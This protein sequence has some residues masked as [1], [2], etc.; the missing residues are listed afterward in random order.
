MK[1]GIR[2]WV[3]LFV[4][5]LFPFEA[6]LMAKVHKGIWYHQQP[7]RANDQ[8]VFFVDSVGYEGFCGLVTSAMG[9]HYFI[10]NIHAKLY[11]IFG[12]V[13]FHPQDD[14]GGLKAKDPYVY[15]PKTTYP[16]ED[17]L[18]HKYVGRHVTTT[19]VA[20]WEIQNI[21]RGVS[22]DIGDYTCRTKWVP[23][24]KIKSY[25]DQNWLVIMN[26]KQ[27]GGHYIL[28]VGWEGDSANIAKQFYYVWDPWKVPLG[29]KENEYELVVDLVGNRANIGTAK[30]ISAYKISGTVF[31]K[32][33][34]DQREDSTVFAFQCLPQN[35]PDINKTVSMKSLWIK[36]LKGIK[37]SDVISVAKLNGV[38][39]LFVNSASETLLQ[40]VVRS[41]HAAGLKVHIVVSVFKDFE[42]S[43]KFKHVEKKW[44]NATDKTYL[45]WFMSHRLKAAMKV[46]PDGIVLNDLWQPV[47]QEGYGQAGKDALTEYCI[48]IKQELMR[49]KSTKKITL[50]AVVPKEPSLH[51]QDILAMSGYLDAIIPLT[52]THTYEEG[53]ARI[54]QWVH[55]L[56]TTIRHG[57]KIWP[58]LETVDRDSNLMTPLEM[59][60]CTAFALANGADAIIYAQYP[61]AEWQWE[62]VDQWSVLKKK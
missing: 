29:L 40:S 57:C 61:L 4:F 44:I 26:S 24:D 36:D 23:F 58:V 52:L 2:Y 32:I 17:F 22:K 56:K 38:T 7:T 8:G 13:D 16:F 42:H 55:R 20:Y 45:N 48:R 46:L 41:A 9:L 30:N 10:P 31:K 39:D 19:G 6:V 50:S 47:S 21:F 11:R 37:I 35:L 51:G 59:D 43:E 15:S 1:Q 14:R 3:L 28:I 25:L 53:P 54:G 62:E 34:K 33:F 60:Q 27:G 49:N 18:G 5:L 12:S